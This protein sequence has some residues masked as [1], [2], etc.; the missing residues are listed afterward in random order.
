M[1]DAFIM[2]FIKS[3]SRGGGALWNNGNALFVAIEEGNSEIVSLILEAEDL[4]LT[5][6]LERDFL[7]EVEQTDALEFAYEVGDG[8]VTELVREKFIAAGLREAP[9]EDSSDSESNYSFDDETD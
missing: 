2:S 8:R 4:D 3:N 5:D 6:T 7:G 1:S 9:E